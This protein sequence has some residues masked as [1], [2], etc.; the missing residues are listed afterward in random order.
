LREK[1]I[2]LLDLVVTLLTVIGTIPYGTYALHH[3]S[4]SLL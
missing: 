1:N 3:D 2:H 4:I